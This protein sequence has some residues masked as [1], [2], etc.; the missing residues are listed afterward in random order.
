MLAQ[1]TELRTALQSEKRER[2]GAEAELAERL[3]M[4]EREAAVAA[5]EAAAAAE[6]LRRERERTMEVGSN[7]AISSYSDNITRERIKLLT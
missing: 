1:V 2:E 7:A 6:G 4:A 3:Q 5:S